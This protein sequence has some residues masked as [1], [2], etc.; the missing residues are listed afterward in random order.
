[1]FTGIAI[2]LT[3]LTYRLNNPVVNG[4]VKVNSVCKET[5]IGIA[6]KKWRLVHRV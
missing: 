2:I 3:Y 6:T 1:M 5:A 4:A